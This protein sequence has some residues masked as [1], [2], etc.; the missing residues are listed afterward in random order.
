MQTTP[1]NLKKVTD[2]IT[3]SY[4]NVVIGEINDHCL[5]LAINHD[6]AYEWHRHPDSDEPDHL[7]R[8]KQ[9]H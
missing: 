2:A 4:E 7:R 1:R 5:R 6:A 8:M 9:R 3:E